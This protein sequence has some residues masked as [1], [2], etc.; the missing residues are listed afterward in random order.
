MTP[1]RTRLGGLAAVLAAGIPTALGGP[2]GAVAGVALVACW[3]VLGPV[4]AFAV[5]TVAVAALSPAWPLEATAGGLGAAFA[6]LLAPDLASARGRRLAAGTLLGAGTLG[7]VA[8]ASQLAWG[9]TWAT[10]VVLVG[11]LAL[12]GY[13]LHRYELVATGALSHE[14]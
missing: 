4:Y 14:Q 11:P 9:T 12:A 13:A 3:Y 8:A 1:D 5:G 7:A 2:V 6:V 10:A